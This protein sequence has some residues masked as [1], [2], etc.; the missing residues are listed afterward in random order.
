MSHDDTTAPGTAAAQASGARPAPDW[1]VEDGLAP[2]VDDTPPG[3][4]YRAAARGELALPFCA[5]CR[6]PLEPEQRLCDG[7]GADDILWE[8]VAPRGTV[9]SATLVHRLEPGLVR[10]RAPYPV[11]DIEL[12]SGHRLIMTTLA[13]ATAPPAVG[14]P[15]TIG[16]R[17]VGGVH[18]PA[19]VPAAADS[20]TEDRT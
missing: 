14:E 8:T 5:A 9:H 19:A 1:L 18:L 16:F 13:P 11:L 6:L 17:T 12:L 2:V 3:P 4:F 10:T 20:E 7:C 15:V